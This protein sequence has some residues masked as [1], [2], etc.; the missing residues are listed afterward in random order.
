MVKVIKEAFD[1]TIKLRFSSNSEDLTMQ[2]Y[3]DLYD[4]CDGFNIMPLN[5]EVPICWDADFSISGGKC[6]ISGNIA[7]GG[8]TDGTVKITMPLNKV[9]DYYSITVEPFDEESYGT[10]VGI[11]SSHNLF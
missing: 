3:N 2:E 1:G 9:N 11:L 5:E 7:P 6:E 4:L 8:G 10:I